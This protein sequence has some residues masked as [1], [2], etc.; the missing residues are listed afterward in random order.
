M[1]RY[2]LLLLVFGWAAALLAFMELEHEVERLSPEVALV[3]N[4][5]TG[6]VRR[7]NTY[8]NADWGCRP[9]DLEPRSWIFA[10]IPLWPARQEFGGR[11]HIPEGSG[12]RA[13]FANAQF[14]SD[15]V[16]LCIVGAVML[17]VGFFIM[18]IKDGDEGGAPNGGG[19]DGGDAGGE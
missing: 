17:V 2:V 15:I 9:V 18:R 5:F 12:D 3:T 11:L 10:L 7:C 1:Q 14:R 19:D 16:H 13:A 6:T 8:R 4:H